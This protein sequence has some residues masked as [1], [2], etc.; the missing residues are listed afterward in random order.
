MSVVLALLG[1]LTIGYGITLKR[2]RSGTF[3]Y[4]VWVRW[5]WRSLLPP[6]RCMLA[7]GTQCLRCSSLPLSSRL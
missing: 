6:G 2:H 7:Y 1:C 3:F 4:I 5:A